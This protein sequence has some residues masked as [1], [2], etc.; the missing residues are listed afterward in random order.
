MRELST[1]EIVAANGGVFAWLATRA[2]SLRHLYAL[3]HNSSNRSAA[4]NRL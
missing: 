1:K 3:D 4:T 2:L